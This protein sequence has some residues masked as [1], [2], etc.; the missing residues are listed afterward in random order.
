VK[1]NEIVVIISVRTF[2]ISSSDAADVTP[3]VA[4]RSFLP[5][6]L[7]AT[8]AFNIIKVKI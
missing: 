3:S 8:L 6:L 1:L 7:C 4:Y 5:D 2:L